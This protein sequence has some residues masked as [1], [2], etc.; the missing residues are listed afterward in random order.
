MNLDFFFHIPASVICIFIIIDKGHGKYYGNIVPRLLYEMWSNHFSWKIVRSY[1]I[2]SFYLN[3]YFTSQLII[4][5]KYVC[6]SEY[7]H[8][9]CFSCKQNWRLYRTNKEKILA[10]KK[11]NP[12][13]M[14]VGDR[15]WVRANHLIYGGWFMYQLI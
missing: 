15:V 2:N 13:S 1:C 10:K 9:C 11:F 14:M 5:F 12:I 6:A 4:F 7:R 8:K 3:I